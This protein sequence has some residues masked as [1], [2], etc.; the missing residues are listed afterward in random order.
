[1][2][3]ISLFPHVALIEILTEV[4]IFCAKANAMSIS[5][6]NRMQH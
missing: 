6:L 5:F 1:M 3:T 4:D 2:Y